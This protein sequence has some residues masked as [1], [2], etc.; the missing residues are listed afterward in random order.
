ME[1]RYQARID[2]IDELTKLHKRMAKLMEE[3]STVSKLISVVEKEMIAEKMLSE[4]IGKV[5]K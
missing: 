5:K 3:A 4:E 2:K 1:N